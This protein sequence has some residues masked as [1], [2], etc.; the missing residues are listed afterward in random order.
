MDRTLGGIVKIFTDNEEESWS[1]AR[2]NYAGSDQF[3]EVLKNTKL[4]KNN[5]RVW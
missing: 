2:N 1:I 4:A 5:E 3:K